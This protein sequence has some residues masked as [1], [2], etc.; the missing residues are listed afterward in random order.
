MRLEIYLVSIIIPRHVFSALYNNYALFMFLKLK[1]KNL[2][3][4]EN[5]VS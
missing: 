2:F 1:T 5:L 3:L 4:L